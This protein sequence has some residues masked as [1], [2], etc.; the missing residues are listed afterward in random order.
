MLVST[1]CFHRSSD[2]FQR[3]ITKIRRIRYFQVLTHITAERHE[4]FGTDVQLLTKC[5]RKKNDLI[6]VVFYLLL[7]SCRYTLRKT[8]KIRK[9]ISSVIIYKRVR[10]VAD[11]RQH[12][13]LLFSEVG[14]QTQQEFTYRRCDLDGRRRGLRRAVSRLG[15]DRRSTQ[16]TRR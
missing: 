1:L 15:S 9:L 5:I 14:A 11:N 13:T 7:C 8:V 4:T 6:K 2:G 12:Y 16:R 10:D 3:K